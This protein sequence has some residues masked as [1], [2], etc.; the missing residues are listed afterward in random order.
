MV[1]TN[2][3][4]QSWKTQL[5]CPHYDLARAK[6]LLESICVVLRELGVDQIDM[7]YSGA[8]DEGAINSTCYSPEPPTD[9]D[10]HP[11]SE[12]LEDWGYRTLAIKRGGWENNDGSF[13]TITINA[14]RATARFDHNDY[15]TDTVPDPF[16]LE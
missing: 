2:E 7:E 1:L 8:G 13:G 6:K 12:I 3:R 11:L 10:T 15:V 14:Q 16:D 5:Q 4:I 9:F